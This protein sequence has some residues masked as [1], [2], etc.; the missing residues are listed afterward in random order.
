[1]PLLLQA[2]HRTALHAARCEP[3]GDALS[4]A[5]HHGLKHPNGVD[6]NPQVVPTCAS[7]TQGLQT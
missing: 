7:V 6:S 2:V 3:T 1:M 5:A 4:L